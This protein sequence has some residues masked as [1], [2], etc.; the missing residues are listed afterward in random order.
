MAF[1][2]YN[3]PELDV[4]LIRTTDNSILSPIFNT[5]PISLLFIMQ[6]AAVM[7]AAV[8]AAICFWRIKVHQADYSDKTGFWSWK[9]IAALCAV[10]FWGTIALI[11]PGGIL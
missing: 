4:I 6:F 5:V 2:L 3:I 10:Y 7:F 8:C 9:F 1:H 11:L